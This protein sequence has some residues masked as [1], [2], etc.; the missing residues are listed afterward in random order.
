M[1]TNT[2]PDWK[3]NESECQEASLR[4]VFQTHLIK[5]AAKLAYLISALIIKKIE[6]TFY[7]EV[8]ITLNSE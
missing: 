7:V 6:I 2:F 1:H 4:K 3:F 8:R 5:P